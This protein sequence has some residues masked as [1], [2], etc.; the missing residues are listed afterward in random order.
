MNLFSFFFE[1]SGQPSG[2][3]KWHRLPFSS[4]SPSSWSTS[5][6]SFS[7][8]RMNSSENNRKSANIAEWPVLESS[9]GGY[10][11]IEVSNNFHS[12]EFNSTPVNDNE[13]ILVLGP[14]GS[15]DDGKIYHCR[16][17]NSNLT[18]ALNVIF[19]AKILG[20]SKYT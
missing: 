1:C 20:K 10:G 17:S 12:T 7:G 18:R 11:S 4:S 8:S 6:S 15:N 9:R 3:V 14:L 13:N 2:V 16:S 5:S 19:R